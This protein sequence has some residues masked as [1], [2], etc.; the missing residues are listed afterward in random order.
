MTGSTTEHPARPSSVGV[1]HGKDAGGGPFIESFIAPD[2]HKRLVG[3]TVAH[4][5]R[6]GLEVRDVLRAARAW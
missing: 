1:A 5:E 3:W 2:V 4:L 6:G